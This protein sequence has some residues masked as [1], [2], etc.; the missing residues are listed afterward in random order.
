[1]PLREIDLRTELEKIHAMGYIPS[2]KQGDSGVGETLERLLGLPPTN[3][4]GV[5]DCLYRSIPTEIK[6]HRN[7]SVAM[8]TLFCAE[9]KRANRAVTFRDLIGT[10][11]YP[12]D[13]GQPALRVTLSTEHS[14]PQGLRLK[15][16]EAAGA[17][18]MVDR[19]DKRLWWWTPDQFSPKLS[20][21]LLLVGADSRQ[22]NTREE[23]LYR[24][25]T[26]YSSLDTTQFGRL[27]NDGSVTIDLRAYIKPDGS[28]R[29]HG[30]G[31]RIRDVSKLAAC[32]RTAEQIL[33]T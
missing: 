29:N 8:R 21:Q 33:T 3:A 10:Y 15:A 27:V 18:D 4:V 22:S 6:A 19:T 24:T 2:V 32:Y 13:K 26:L 25:A 11:G 1:M 31:F 9:P 7:S 20:K 17:I 5:P 14:N 12:D 30:T 16:N 28:L 23:F